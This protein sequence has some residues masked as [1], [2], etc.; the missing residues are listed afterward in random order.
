VT[1]AGIFKAKEVETNGVVAGSYAVKNSN[2]APTAGDETIVAVKA[3]ADGDGWDDETK[4]D[5]KSVRVKTDAVSET[6]K[7]FVTF[8]GDPGSRYWV[9]KVTDPETGE[10]TNSFSVNVSEAVKQDVKFSWWIVESR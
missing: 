3:D 4:V 5:G 8:E 2:D 1:L 9:E 10:L 6:A 7:I